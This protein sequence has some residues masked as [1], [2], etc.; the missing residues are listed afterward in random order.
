MQ[1]VNS[2]KEWNQ[3]NDKSIKDLYNRIIKKIDK[4][5]NFN[6]DNMYDG[7]YFI[8]LNMMNTSIVEKCNSREYIIESIIDMSK[9]D[10][11]NEY[12]IVEIEFATWPNDTIIIGILVE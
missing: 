12:T 1:L 7:V 11:Y 9:L 4:I 10:M 5:E 2:I 8:E 6:E 3:K